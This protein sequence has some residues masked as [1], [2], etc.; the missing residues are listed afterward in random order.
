VKTIVRIG[1]LS[2]VLLASVLSCG[3]PHDGSQAQGPARFLPRSIAQTGWSRPPELSKFSGDSLFQYIDGAAEMYHKYDFVDVNVAEYSRY[4]DEITVDLYR[5]GSPDM[6]FGMY[7]TLR[8]DE[9]ETIDLGVTGFCFGPSLVFVRGRYMVG[10]TGYDESG[11]VISG[12]RTIAAAVDSLLPGKTELPRMFAL[13][14]RPGY[15]PHTE[16]VLAES[17]L[18]RGFL[19]D[20]YT[21]DYGLAG[22]TVTLFVT[23]DESG[24]KLLRWSEITPSP[25]RFTDLPFDSDGLAVS[26]AWHGLVVAGPRA[27]KLAGIVGYSVSHRDF[28]TAWLDSFPRPTS[29]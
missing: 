5:F 6:A 11:V 14:P 29:P 3:G 13:L 16:K 1:F 15:L 20:V 4:D 2:V 22:D 25:E 27:G 10:L 7:T 18:G 21:A 24:Q 9:S 26:D 19:T 12:L 23:D 28:L 8:P 17:F